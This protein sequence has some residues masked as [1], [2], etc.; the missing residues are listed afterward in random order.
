M[1]GTQLESLN[2]AARVKIFMAAPNRVKRI[3]VKIIH[4][5]ILEHSH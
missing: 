3:I 2:V 5:H 4:Y 1:G